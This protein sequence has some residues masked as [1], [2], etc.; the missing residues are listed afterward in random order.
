MTLR[1][2]DICLKRI[3]RRQRNNY[4]LRAALHG[5]KLPMDLP[6]SAKSQQV[7]PEDTEKAD[8]L[9]QDAI[10]RRGMKKKGS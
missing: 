5:I 8:K 6:E 3:S 2:I 7:R 1:E 4:A 10:K 9:M